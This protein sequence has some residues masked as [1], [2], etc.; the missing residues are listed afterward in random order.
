VRLT[1]YGNRVLQ[2]VRD[3]P[4]GRGF[5]LTRLADCL[6]QLR[7]HVP[8]IL[9]IPCHLRRAIK[10]LRPPASVPAAPDSPEEGLDNHGEH[11]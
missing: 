1:L 5:S 4:D 2:P 10:V 9:L 3:V 7:K 11:R 8:E 6:A